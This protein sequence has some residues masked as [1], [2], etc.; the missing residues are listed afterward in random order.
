MNNK[1][2]TG[3]IEQLYDACRLGLSA[4]RIVES[5]QILSNQPNL[6]VSQSIKIMQNAVVTYEY[7]KETK[8]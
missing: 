5:T 1:E 2:Q 4:L 7:H 3:L 8:H 6:E